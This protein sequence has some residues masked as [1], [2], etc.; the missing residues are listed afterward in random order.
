MNASTFAPIPTAVVDPD[1][2]A[3]PCPSALPGLDNT[4]AVGSFGAAAPAPANPAPTAPAPAPTAPRRPV[5]PVASTPPRG[6]QRR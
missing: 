3:D 6:P 1:P 4:A 2:P 5:P